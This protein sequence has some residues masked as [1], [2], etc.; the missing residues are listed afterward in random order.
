MNRRLL[1]LAAVCAAALMGA[2]A[3]GA[4]AR[5]LSQNALSR[6]DR[7]TLS[8][9]AAPSTRLTIGISLARPDAAGEQALLGKLF[10]RSSSEYHQFLT[11]S[12]FAARFG[13]P[14]AQVEATK[15]WLQ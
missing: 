8:G 11:P 12:Q 10:D 1:A 3:G 15:A 7:A 9:A 5:V 13:F 2:G 14:A 6:L 4:S